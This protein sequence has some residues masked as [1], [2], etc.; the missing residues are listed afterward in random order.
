MGKSEPGTFRVRREQRPVEEYPEEQKCGHVTHQGGSWTRRNK[1]QEVR[2]CI[3]R[4]RTKRD[5]AI[6]KATKGLQYRG[7]DSEGFEVWK[8][9]NA[10]AR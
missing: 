4:Q 2:A 6:L 8:V 1:V 9:P 10:P 5:A 7:V 3:L